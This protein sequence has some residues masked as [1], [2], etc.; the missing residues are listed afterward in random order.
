MKVGNSLFIHKFAVCFL[1]IWPVLVTPDAYSGPAYSKI[2]VTATVMQK[3]PYREYKKFQDNLSKKI[4]T[5]IENR[6]K[7]SGRTLRATIHLDHPHGDGG[8]SIEEMD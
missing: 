6:A 3:N 1:L 8:I 2:S 4:K 5:Y 7:I